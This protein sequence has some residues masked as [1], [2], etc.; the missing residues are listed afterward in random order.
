MIELEFD[1]SQVKQLL[2]AVVRN[3]TNPQPALHKIGEVS[4]AGIKD[5]FEE[6]G[7][8]SSPDSLIG[9]SKKWK[10]LSPVTKKIKARQGKKGPYQILVDST[11]LRDSINSK[12]DKESVEIGTNVEYAATQHFGA[13]KGEFGIHDVLIKAHIRNMTQTGQRIGKGGKPGKERKLS[14]KQSVR[15]H[16]RKQPMPFGDIPARP[17][18]TIHPTTLEDMVEILSKFILAE[19]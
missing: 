13:K 11:R 18:M 6:G 14:L 2:N 12:T 3:M 17:F 8:Y 4:K 19:K 9:G 5:N 7:A 16:F 15:G 10:P 1:D